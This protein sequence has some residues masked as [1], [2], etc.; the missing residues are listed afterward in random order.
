MTK[1]D[2]VVKRDFSTKKF[3]LDKITN[4]IFKAMNAVDQ[5]TE[6]DAQNVALSV[7]K[8][9]QT[10]KEKDAAIPRISKREKEILQLI[11]EEHTTAQIAE[12]LF[13]SVTTV[14]THRKNLLRK[15]GLKNTA[16]LMRFAFENSIVS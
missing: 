1:I 8:A 6:E 16:G 4:A 13:I 7:Y 12:E 5:G 10:R 2:F 3:E 14:E 15:L 9:L 11:S